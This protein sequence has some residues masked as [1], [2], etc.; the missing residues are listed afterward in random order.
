MYLNWLQVDIDVDQN[1]LKI[2]AFSR[3]RKITN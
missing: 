1:D 3:L 2:T